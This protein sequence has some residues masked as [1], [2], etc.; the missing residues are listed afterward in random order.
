[1]RNDKRRKNK[2][3][4]PVDP[5]KKCELELAKQK[6]HAERKWIVVAFVDILGFATWVRRASNSPEERQKFVIHLYRKLTYYSTSKGY[7]VKLLGDGAMIVRELV[8]GHNCQTVMTMLKDLDCLHKYIDRVIMQSEF[9]RLGGSRIRVVAGHV[10]KLRSKFC[11]ND[12]FLQDDYIGYPI[13]LAARL[14]EVLKTTEPIICH[15]SVKDIVGKKEEKSDF[16]F[17]LLKL[18]GE[19]RLDGID[20]EDLNSL[21][22][23]SLKPEIEE[24]PVTPIIEPGD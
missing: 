8:A 3:K 5:F 16:V 21:W 2:T 12:C 15:E 22:A 20:E 23:V 18:E 7:F 14:L 9:P 4:K 24:A 10:L 17:R 6:V 11:A 13:N 19:R 1:M